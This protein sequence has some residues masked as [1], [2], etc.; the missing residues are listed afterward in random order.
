MIYRGGG[1]PGANLR[2]RLRTLAGASVRKRS[3]GAIP[4]A[5]YRGLSA[6]AGTRRWK[7]ERGPGAPI[8][9]DVE[10][11]RIRNSESGDIP[12]FTA[13][14]RNLPSEVLFADTGRFLSAESRGFSSPSI[15]FQS[16]AAHG[17]VVADGQ[18]RLSPE[19]N[20]HATRPLPSGVRDG[21]WRRRRN[22]PYLGCRPTRRAG[23]YRPPG[24]DAEGKT[25]NA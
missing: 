11:A 17:I 15:R 24:T 5:S 1:G 18:R 3:E 12:P 9:P 19:G 4:S 22:I 10:R 2:S 25:A 14:G 23:G 8:W 20:P 6:V 16:G 13:T 7:R 21:S